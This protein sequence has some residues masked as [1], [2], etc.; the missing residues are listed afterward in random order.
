MNIL[1][2]D[3]EI[4]V[5][6]KEP[7]VPVQSDKTKDKDMVN[8]LRNYVVDSKHGCERQKGIPFIGLV[9][10]LDRPVGGVMVF[11]KT[12]DALKKLN[13]QITEGKVSKRYLAVVEAPNDENIVY[14][15]INEKQWMELEDYLLK[16]GRTNVSKV[17][18]NDVKGAKKATLYYRILDIKENKIMLLDIKLITGRHHQIRVQMANNKMPLVGDTKYNPHCEKGQVMLYSYTLGFK[19]PRTNK[20]LEYRHIP[21][22]GEFALFSY[23]NI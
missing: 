22:H 18:K 13:K 16:D 15:N 19:H 2:E 8:M 12:S 1:Y 6:V 3:K 17:V 5:V 9:H 10:R 20:Q 7:G 11:A 21:I 4:I 23:D 14:E